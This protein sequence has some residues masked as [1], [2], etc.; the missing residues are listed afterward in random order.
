L[1]ALAL[2]DTVLTTRDPARARRI[3]RRAVDVASSPAGRVPALT[4]AVRVAPTP[5][6]AQELYA[7]LVQTD[8]SAAGDSI[9]HLPRLG[10]IYAPAH[11]ASAAFASGAADAQRRLE[12]VLAGLPSQAIR[13]RARAH[14][15]LATIA[16]RR[17]DTATAERHLTASQAA[18]RTRTV[19]SQLHT[20]ARVAQSA[21][22]PDLA[23]A[24]LA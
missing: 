24:A 22:Y 16:V 1:L 15:R 19:I 9:S 11:I 17:R 2:R 14:V 4:A 3:A 23:H 18:P 5:A 7:L 21:G 10:G 12:D 20:F 8:P 13:S 6:A